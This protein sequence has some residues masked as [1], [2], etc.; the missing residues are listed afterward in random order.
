MR[1]HEA[2]SQGASQ[3]QRIRVALSIG[4]A[5]AFLFAWAVWIGLG[6]GG[7]TDYALFSVWALGSTAG[8]YYG[9]RALHRP[10]WGAI[11]GGIGGAA[12]FFICWNVAQVYRSGSIDHILHPQTTTVNGQTVILALGIAGSAMLGIAATLGAEGLTI[13]LR[14]GEEPGAPAV[15]NTSASAQE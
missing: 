11:Y 6:A 1:I 13:Q 12:L 14:S 9:D 4:G 8:I 7:W 5:L 10:I 2:F 3:R 15:T